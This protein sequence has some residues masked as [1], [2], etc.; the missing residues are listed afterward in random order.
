MSSIDEINVLPISKIG[1]RESNYTEPA[2]LTAAIQS[3][4]AFIPP[5][6]TPNT[7]Q[8]LTSVL[9]TQLEISALVKG[10]SNLM[11]NQNLKRYC[12]GKLKLS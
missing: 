12:F 9:R 10:N 1:D 7:I 5:F 4:E 3:I 11:V 2:N 6:N 8:Y